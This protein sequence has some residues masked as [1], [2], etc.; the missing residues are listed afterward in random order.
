MKFKCLIGF[1]FLSLTVSSALAGNTY[2]L[3]VFK[4]H[5]GN[6]SGLG[7]R[8]L[9]TTQSN[10]V[11][12]KIYDQ[13]GTLLATENKTLAARGQDAFLVGTSLTSS[14][15]IMVESDHELAG[16]NFLGEN[17]IGTVNYHIADVPFTRTPS[18][19]LVF[20]H[21][22]HNKN[23]ETTI[24]T[25]NTGDAEATVI[26]TYLDKTGAVIKEYYSSIP[27]KGSSEVSLG[28]FSS[29]VPEIKGGS[30]TIFASQEIAAFAVY[31]NLK[32]GNL[33]Y[34]GLNAVDIS[35]LNDYFTATLND[36]ESFSFT[37]GSVTSPGDFSYHSEVWGGSMAKGFAA[38]GLS[39]FHSIGN[40]S[41]QSHLKYYCMNAN[42]LP[43][44]FYDSGTVFDSNL[45]AT[46]E[47]EVRWIKTTENKYALII[48]TQWSSS[49]MT[50]T[51]FY[52][53]GAFTY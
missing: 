18:Q 32:S 14:G 27:A 8:N 52:P 23:W 44:T 4:P 15:W 7:I 25:V 13:A 38:G 26:F 1:L 39:A 36:G 20:P 22:A 46:P 37:S 35:H 51:Y 19:E 31:S 9:S 12:V 40:F 28:V 30:V 53:Y 24:Y 43:D 2:Y 34:A 45:G 47:N 10:Q 3:P 11:T 48:I 21:V 41:N 50:F 5:P 49:S 33:S 6:W 42:Y 16:L 17:L 29:T